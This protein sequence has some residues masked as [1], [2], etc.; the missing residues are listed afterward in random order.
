MDYLLTTGTGPL[1]KGPEGS[2]SSSRTPNTNHMDMPF[3]NLRSFP[4]PRGPW[5]W[6]SRPSEAENSNFSE[7][8]HLLLV[9]TE[10]GFQPNQSFCSRKLGPSYQS[11]PMTAILCSELQMKP[12]GPLRFFLWYNSGSGTQPLDS[13]V[14][15]ITLSARWPQSQTY[16][17]S[18]CN[19]SQLQAI[20][21]IV[22][23]T[24]QKLT[25]L[26]QPLGLGSSLPASHPTPNPIPRVCFFWHQLSQVRPLEWHGM[27]SCSV[28]PDSLWPHGLWPARLLCPWDSLGK[29]IGVGRHSLLQGIFLT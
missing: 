3:L 27:L 7:D 26:L 8:L 11:V 23:P 1:L 10:P 5:L 22:F 4:V 15:S 13:T 6:H 24:S 20:T 18:P 16:C 28:V 9:D 17:E 21:E 25:L 2:R 14:F 29:N 12:P 19:P